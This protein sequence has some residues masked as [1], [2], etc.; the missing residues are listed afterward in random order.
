[1]GGG[2][3]VDGRWGF[4]IGWM[5]VRMPSGIFGVWTACC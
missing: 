5:G 1:M 4:V 3:E 2:W